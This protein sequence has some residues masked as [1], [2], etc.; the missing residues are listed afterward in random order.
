MIW[1]FFLKNR[2]KISIYE[3][4]KTSWT[5]LKVMI[6]NWLKVDFLEKRIRPPF[7]LR[8]SAYYS[9]WFMCNIM[10]IFKKTIDV[11]WRFHRL[12]VSFSLKIRI[13]DKRWISILSRSFSSF[14][15]SE[16]DFQDISGSDRVNC[17]YNWRCVCLKMLLE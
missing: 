5:I 12:L 3:K 2:R 13:V 4:L 6:R 8:E 14:Q 15:W 1:I 17:V 9:R 7:F 16:F 10:I 11:T